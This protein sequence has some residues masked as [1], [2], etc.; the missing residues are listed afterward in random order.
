MQQRRH[1][2]LGLSPAQI[3]LSLPTMEID[4]TALSGICPVNSIVECAASK[5]RTLSGHC[6]NVNHPLR[7]AVYEPMQRFLKPDYADGELNVYVA[8]KIVVEVL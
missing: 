2:R 5:Y 4:G 6:N 8:S 3:V 7:G 1:F